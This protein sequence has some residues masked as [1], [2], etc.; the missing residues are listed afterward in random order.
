VHRYSQK[1]ARL[2]ETID[3]GDTSLVVAPGG[4]HFGLLPYSG[5][6]EIRSIARTPAGA[7]VLSSQSV[8]VPLPNWGIA[9]LAPSGRTIAIVHGPQLSLIDVSGA[10]AGGFALQQ[11]WGLCVGASFSASGATLW[12]SFKA[13]GHNRIVGI[14]VATS[15]PLGVLRVGSEATPSHLHR[16]H[17]RDEEVLVECSASDNEVALARRDGNTIALV[18]QESY[19]EG[20]VALGIDAKGGW[21]RTDRGGLT[22]ASQGGFAMDR[23]T[24]SRPEWLDEDAEPEVV[25][26]G[27][28]GML[29]DGPLTLMTY[30]VDP[31]LPQQYWHRLYDTALDAVLEMEIELDADG[32]RCRRQDGLAEDLVILT[33]ENEYVVLD[34]AAWLRVPEPTAPSVPIPRAGVF[35]SDASHH[36]EVA[37]ED[38]AV[39]RLWMLIY[40]SGEVRCTERPVDDE[41]S[42]S[43]VEKGSEWRGWLT[44]H[45][46]GALEITLR[47]AWGPRSFQG[48]HDSEGL[49]LAQVAPSPL[50]VYRFEYRKE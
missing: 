46:N 20:V 18:G 27:I 39:L 45:P 19:P 40:G 37:S 38:E 4:R 31:N 33:Y 15:T 21:Y 41:L 17:P 32:E 26:T 29:G 1:N 49:L 12:L 48:R 8:S 50:D 5:P 28:G 34:W 25:F 3:R 11:D 10:S 9:A 2:V 7:A 44:E 30:D 42:R 13:T 6:I 16:V 23:Q 24:W 22:R 14:D 43:D 36:P 47:S 35:V